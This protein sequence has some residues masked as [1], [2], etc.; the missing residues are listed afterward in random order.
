VKL[1]A[2]EFG[3]EGGAC[4]IGGGALDEV[5]EDRQAQA[6]LTVKLAEVRGGMA[7]TQPALGVVELV[8][9]EGRVGQF[10]VHLIEGV[11]RNILM[12]RTGC[13]HRSWRGS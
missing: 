6:E 4:G 8:E 2:V 3:G 9:R 11:I 13:V 1:S 12:E 10:S 7:H 5:R